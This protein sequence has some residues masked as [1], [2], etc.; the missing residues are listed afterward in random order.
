[1]VTL[2]KKSCQLSDFK[3]K[4]NVKVQGKSYLQN[5]AI[6]IIFKKQLFESQMVQMDQTDS[7]KCWKFVQ[8]LRINRDDTIT[9]PNRNF[10]VNIYNFLSHCRL[11]KY[12][13]KKRQTMIALL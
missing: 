8:K 2:T 1:M 6:I 13:L 5:Y 10:T 9:K 4:E 3:P 12:I 11:T 7:I